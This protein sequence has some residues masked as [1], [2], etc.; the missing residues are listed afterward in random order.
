VE[1][2][3]NRVEAFRSQAAKAR[4]AGD[5]RKAKEADKQ[6]AQWEEWLKTAQGAVDQ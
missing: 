3:R 5:E 1:Q 4:A 2:F 6:A